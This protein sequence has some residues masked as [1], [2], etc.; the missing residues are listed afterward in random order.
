MKYY[1]TC[2]MCGSNLDPGEKCDCEVHQRGWVHLR[3]VRSGATEAGASI[4]EKRNRGG[5]TR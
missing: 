1:W 5:I 3:N 2:P 4:Q